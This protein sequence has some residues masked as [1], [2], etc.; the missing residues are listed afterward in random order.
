MSY[1]IEST[2]LILAVSIERFLV[3]KSPLRSR[4]YWKTRS[5]ILLIGGIFLTTGI[6]TFYHHFAY[7]CQIFYMCSGRQL[8]H[9]C[10]SAA[11]EAH[12]TS[13]MDGTVVQNSFP[14]RLYI[15]I[16]TISNAVM[17]VFMP[18]MGIIV[19]NIMIIHCLHQSS[20][21]LRIEAPGSHGFK[22]IQLVICFLCSSE[23][24]SDAK[25]ADGKE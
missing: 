4:I 6:L 20:R 1:G 9:A 22:H 8:A 24:R 16:S 5:K 21:V 7:D 18:M 14:K 10:Y 3:I 12:P 19:L 17:V 2:R 25:A 13:W 23:R 15:Q 11:V